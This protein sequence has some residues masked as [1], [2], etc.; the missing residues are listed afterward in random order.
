LPIAIELSRPSIMVGSSSTTV[1]VAGAVH[2]AS[3]QLAT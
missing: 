1:I 3:S 2:A